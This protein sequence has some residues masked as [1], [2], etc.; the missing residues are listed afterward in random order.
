M[1]RIL[2]DGTKLRQLRV[3]S[4]VTQIQM[5]QK[6]GISRDTIIAIEKNVPGTIAKLSFEKVN[7]WGRYCRSR[8]ARSTY[9]EWVNYLKKMLSL[10]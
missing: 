8:V 3:D 5:A 7:D 4:G 6:L 10:D 9:E 1:N 2:V